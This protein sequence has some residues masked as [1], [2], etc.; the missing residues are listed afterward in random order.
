MIAAAQE[1]R[2]T[3][4]K[5]DAAFPEQ[6]IHCCLKQA[7]L[8]TS[9]LD[10]IAFYEK[11][12]AKFD[13]LLETYLAFAPFGFRSFLKAIPLWLQEKLHQPRAIRRAL[14]QAHRAKLVFLEHLPL[15]LQSQQRRIQTHGARPLRQTSLR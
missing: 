14:H 6:A 10:Y 7:G 13:R 8:T 11:P 9:D 2:F 5:H 4:R 1:E 3:R 12:L 15:R